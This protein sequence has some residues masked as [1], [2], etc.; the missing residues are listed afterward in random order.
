MH[1]HSAQMPMQTNIYTYKIEINLLK[2]EKIY[3]HEDYR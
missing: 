1:A 2:K 3:T